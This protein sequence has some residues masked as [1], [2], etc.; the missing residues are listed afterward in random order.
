MNG[1][2][3]GEYGCTISYK[4]ESSHALIPNKQLTGG[5]PMINQG[6]EVVKFE[7]KYKNQ[8]ICLK[9]A[10]RPDLTALVKE[11]EAIKAEE[12]SER[13][14]KYA[15]REAAEKAAD[16]KFIDKMNSEAEVLRS[17]IPASHVFVSAKQIGD[18]DGW[19]IMKY[20]VDGVELK[21][22]QVN[23]IGCANAIRTGAIGAFESIWVCSIDRDELVTIK[24][25]NIKAATDTAEKKAAYQDKLQNT[26]IPADAISDY[27]RYHGSS[28]K[29][30]AAEDEG[31]WAMIEKWSPYIEA[32]HGMHPDKFISTLNEAMREANY[33]INEG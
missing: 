11:Y 27:N 3:R 31:A 8:I 29:A 18:S 1:I 19:P 6:V 21:W 20:E 7:E 16:Q 10:D 15:E 26:E 30:W 14:R 22:N 24:A 25:E 9:Y 2:I 13:Q 12:E 5:Y 17:Q 4:I 33:G 32:Q 28:E 23:V